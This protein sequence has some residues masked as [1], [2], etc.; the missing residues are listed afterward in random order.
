MIPLFGPIAGGFKFLLFGLIGL[1][2]AIGAA[3]WVYQDASGRGNGNAAIW[4]GG[5]L[6]AG[7]FL[8]MLGLLLVLGLYFVVGR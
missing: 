6:I 8:N 4:A 2:I 7:L 5:V 1:L 3:Y